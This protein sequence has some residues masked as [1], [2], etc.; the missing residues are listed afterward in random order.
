M[1]EHRPTQNERIIAYL[2]E[3]PEGITQLEAGQYLGVM[4]LASRITD[5]RRRGYN[6][7][8][9]PVTV[10]NRWEEKCRVTRY[11]LGE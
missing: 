6:I 4:R 8:A 1:V 9:D 7:I 5:L 3:H 2:E 11:R 10:H